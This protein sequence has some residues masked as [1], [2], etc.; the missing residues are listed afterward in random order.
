MLSG[1]TLVLWAALLWL[2]QRNVLSFQPRV[3]TRTDPRISRGVKDVVTR[4]W[5]PLFETKSTG[6]DPPINGELDARAKRAQKLKEDALNYPPVI[7]DPF[8]EASDPK[9][10][11]KGTIGQ[12]DFVV[13]REG[14]PTLEE[15]SNENLYRIL[16]RRSNVT[17]LE[18]NT[19]VWKCLG[20][21]FDPESEE[22][23]AKEVFPKWKERFPTPPDL[24][25]MQRIYSK[26]VD[27]PCLKNNQHLVRSIPADNKQS[28]KEQLKPLGF[29]G[30]KVS[31]LTPNLTRRAQCSNWLLYY[32]EELFGL[33]LEELQERRRQ[34][35]E[36]DEKQRIESGQEKPWSPPVT[37]VF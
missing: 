33:T 22:W 7:L 2:C 5:T 11:V 32:R 16:V 4:L 15:L 26:D 3:G 36:A 13:S 35:K 37:E 17:D 18:V 10:P 21:R 6:S 23:T 27:G 8:P 30:Y 1:V 12:G 14:G 20:Y 31:E 24:I 28:L 25:G 29:T 19:L 34:K 9:Y